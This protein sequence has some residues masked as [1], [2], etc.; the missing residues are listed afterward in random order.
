MNVG[1]RVLSRAA[2]RRLLF[3]FVHAGCRRQDATRD[4]KTPSSSSLLPKPRVCSVLE[5]P[6]SQTWP[7]I[8]H[9]K[10]RKSQPRPFL[11]DVLRMAYQTEAV[12]T[13]LRR[14]PRLV[15]CLVQL[16]KHQKSTNMFY[17]RSLRTCHYQRQRLWPLRNRKHPSRYPHSQRITLDHHIVVVVIVF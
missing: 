8:C 4:E 2:G 17:R 7:L 3:P 11:R 9:W 13:N 5:R 16:Y 6:S 10:V 14:N 1:N 12:K 15:S